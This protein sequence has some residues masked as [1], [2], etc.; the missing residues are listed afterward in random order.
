MKHIDDVEAD[1]FPLDMIP[2]IPS[3]T[4]LTWLAFALALRR[5]GT[6][7]FV[8]VKDPKEAER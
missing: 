7:E 5:L 1:G 3:E 4:P 2:S 6:T 8:E